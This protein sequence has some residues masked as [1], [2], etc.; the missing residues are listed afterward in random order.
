[1][2]C[3]FQITAVLYPMPVQGIQLEQ[4]Q[5]G[6][7]VQ[8]KRKP[9]YGIVTQVDDSHRPITIIWDN[10]SDDSFAYT[11]DEINVHNISVLCPYLPQQTLVKLPLGTTVKLNNGESLTF[12]EDVTFLVDSID[13]EQ[14][15]IIHDN[16]RYQFPLAQFPGQPFAN[17]VE[18]VQPITEPK[19]LSVQELQIK[20]GIWLSLNTPPSF[21]E[22]VSPAWLDYL[23]AKF[24]SQLQD[25]YNETDLKTAWTQ[26]WFQHTEKLAQDKG[27][28]GFSMGMEVIDL[29]TA[30]TIGKV[31]AIDW[32][33]SRPIEITTD[34]K[35]VLNYKASELHNLG[36][37]PIPP[38]IQLSE[39]VAYQGTE[40]GSYYQVFIGLRTKRLAKA[41]LKP[42][43]KQLGRLSPLQRHERQEFRHLPKKQ[44]EYQLLTPKHKSFK[45]RWEVLQAVA[46]WNLE[47]MPT[48]LKSG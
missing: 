12:D 41:W 48:H 17:L 35:K 13:P 8:F 44:W 24:T 46:D 5:L 6:S 14:I 10:D 32:Q 19:P 11:W 22:V 15:M 7:I 1:M 2:L 42:L 18:L 3:S 30:K 36:F 20:A 26:A 40:T 47:K 31:T 23:K 37:I 28:Y 9:I 39:N 38:I 21:L 43:K 27:V 25:N 33:H 29:K 16:N 45:K 34:S 4:F